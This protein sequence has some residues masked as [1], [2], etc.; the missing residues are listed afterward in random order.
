MKTQRIAV[1]VT[2][3]LAALLGGANSSRA[4]ADKPRQLQIEL[5]I[6]SKG[7]IFKVDVSPAPAPTPAPAP[8]LDATLPLFLDQFLSHLGDVLARPD[9]LDAFTR[10]LPRVLGSSSSPADV[11]AKANEQNRR[12]REAVALQ[13]ARAPIELRMFEPLSVNFKNLP[14]QQALKDLGSFTGLRIT[15]DY[16]AL[17]AAGVNLQREITMEMSN[18][19]LDMVL[20]KVLEPA[21]LTYE[22][23]NN[24]VLISP[25]APVASRLEERRTGE[26]VR[27]FDIGERHRRAGELELARRAFQQVH[28]LTPTTIHGRMAIVRIVQIEADERLRDASEEQGGDRPGRADDP[29]TVLRELR[30]QTVPLGLVEVSY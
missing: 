22:I 15:P 23:R 29:E 1:G 17:D 10:F 24:V 12:Q 13:K 8:H 11:N 9:R 25:P 21:R 30:R 5:G 27:L 16:A 28:M 19:T 14:L 6:G 4:Q 20:R 7:I 2:M 26:S 18:A 3:A